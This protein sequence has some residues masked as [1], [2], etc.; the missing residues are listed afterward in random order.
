[1]FELMILSAVMIGLDAISAKLYKRRQDVLYGPYIR[2][3]RT[4]Q[5][6]A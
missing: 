4:D 1:M 6:A 5:R 2:R 3:E